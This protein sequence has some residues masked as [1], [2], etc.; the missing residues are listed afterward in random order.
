MAKTGRTVGI[1]HETERRDAGW[2][3]AGKTME[4]AP[5]PSGE[6]PDAV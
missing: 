5:E 3:P 6:E 2:K 1:S 4:A